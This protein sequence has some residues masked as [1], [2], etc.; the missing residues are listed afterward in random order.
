MTCHKCFF[1]LLLYPILHP[2][3]I[4]LDLSTFHQ[5]NIHRQNQYGSLLSI[6]L[7]LDF[8][9]LFG[10][11]WTSCTKIWKKIISTSKNQSKL[12]FQIL[13]ETNFWPNLQI[14]YKNINKQIETNNI[15]IHVHWDNYRLWE[16]F[17]FDCSYYFFYQIRFEIISKTIKKRYKKLIQKICSYNISIVN[18]QISNFVIIK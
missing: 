18:Y 11:F 10:R 15:R 7:T 2:L 1:K 13:W 9:E 17:I 5:Y 6:S 4:M 8:A 14:G 16:T 3:F 12:A